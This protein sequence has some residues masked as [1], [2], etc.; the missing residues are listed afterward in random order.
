MKEEAKSG[1]GN[2]GSKWKSIG[3]IGL[4]GVERREHKRRNWNGT[5]DKV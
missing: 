4:G 1:S 3:C 2:E 5:Q